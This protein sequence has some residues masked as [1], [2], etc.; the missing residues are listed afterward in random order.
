MTRQWGRRI[1]APLPAAKMLRRISPSLPPMVDLRAWCG[2]IKN[3]GDLGSCTGHAFSSGGEWIARKWLGAAPVLSPL[4]LYVKELQANGNFP[5]DA[6]SDGTTGCEVLT[7]FGCCED[8]LYPDASQVIKHPTGRMNAN[9]KTHAMGA[10]H[11]LVGSVT[12][13][14][15]LG[16]PVPWPIEI[17]FTVYSSFESAEV[18]TTGIYN[19]DPS[20]ESVLGGHEILLV[21]YDLGISPQLR[22]PGAGPSFLAQNS[23][24][25][26]WGWGGSGFV[27]LATS[28]LDDPQTD[29]K[30]VHSGPPWP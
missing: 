1:P 9:A 2:P 16:D 8:W 22:P 26:G 6:G 12:A 29:L 20:T 27:W 14:S 19:P 24:G 30:I 7:S 11:G 10:Y 17:G 21:G 15:V 28:V 4:Y 18:A 13:Q 3:Q 5:Q 25:T 23:W